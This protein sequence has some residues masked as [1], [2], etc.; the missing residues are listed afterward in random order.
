M[1]KALKNIRALHKK[2]LQ[3]IK[4]KKKQD[5]VKRKKIYVQIFLMPCNVSF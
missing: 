2:L 3:E 1:I 4:K 5:Y